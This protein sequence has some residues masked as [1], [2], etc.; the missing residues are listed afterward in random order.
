MAGIESLL[1]AAKTA[2][3][4]KTIATVAQVGGSALG[5]AGRYR[6]G[7]E[8]KAQSQY[9]ANLAEQQADA[10]KAAGQRRA[11]AEY[12]RGRL[13]A[14]RQRQAAAVSGGGED[15]SV[16]GLMGQ[17]QNITANNAAT[18][19]ADAETQAQGYDERARIARV[20]GS[21]AAT[22]G[23]LGALGAGLSGFSS[24]YER[25]GRPNEQTS[26]VNSRYG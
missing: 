20:N 5:A 14:A 17:V 16:I 23:T 10:A 9:Q 15:P 22:A 19:F 6:A 18:I 8:A 11:A 13:Y 4:L 7:Q 12:R 1:A 25:F 21:N 3:T 2:G 26:K 24:M